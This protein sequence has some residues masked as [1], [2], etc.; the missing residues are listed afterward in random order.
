M[1]SLLKECS[2]LKI[3]CLNHEAL[4]FLSEKACIYKGLEN[5]VLDLSE[6]KN[7][8]KD[9]QALM[10]FADFIQG[11]EK[12]NFLSLHIQPNES[13]I[14]NVIQDLYQLP[15][16]KSLKH[17]V[18]KV[19]FFSLEPKS[20]RNGLFNQLLEI[21]PSLQ[22]LEDLQLTVNMNGFFSLKPLEKM[23]EKFP[24]L[25]ELA[26]FLYPHSVWSNNE[27]SFDIPFHKMNNLEVL[28]LKTSEYLSYDSREKINIQAKRLRHVETLE[29][30]FGFW[31]KIKTSGDS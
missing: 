25:K 2:L 17:Y 7:S 15:C 9:E 11:L 20:E 14:I 30:C 23:L 18:F 31:K 6:K 29:D 26:I 22:N 13:K 28:I 1:D 27:I 21:L 4:S 5:I 3:L 12:L 10:K 8:N 16:I 19:N 24:R